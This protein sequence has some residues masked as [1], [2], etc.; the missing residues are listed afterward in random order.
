MHTAERQTKRNDRG[1]LVTFLKVRQL[2]ISA[3]VNP[4]GQPFATGGGW[5]VIQSNDRDFGPGGTSWPRIVTCDT[6]ESAEACARSFANP[7]PK[8]GGW[9]EF[10]DDPRAAA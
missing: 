7:H 2:P 8:Y 9:Y 1:I 4:N 3:G 5:A 6:K 10:V